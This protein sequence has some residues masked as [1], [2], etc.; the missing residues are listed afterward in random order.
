M[1]NFKK[2]SLLSNVACLAALIACAP[3]SDA[4]EQILI[5]DVK[6]VDEPA[7]VIEAQPVQP[8]VEQVDVVIVEEDI[9]T[10]VAPEPKCS[11]EAQQGGLII[12]QLP[13]GTEVSLEGVKVAIVGEAGIATIGLKQQQST[14]AIITWDDGIGKKGTIEVPVLPRKDEYR[15]IQGFNCDKVDA[16]TPEQ[17]KHAGESWVKKVEAFANLNSPKS[18]IIAFSKPS[19]GPYSS[20]FGP[21]RKYIG[22]SKVTGKPCESMSVHRGLDMAV[23]VGTELL[24]PMAGTVTLADPDL[25]YEGGAIFL[26]HGYGLVSVFMHLSEVDVKAGQIVQSGER[27]GATGNTGRTT[28]PHL[29]WSVKWQNLAREDRKGDFYIDP[30]IVLELPEW[31]A[32]K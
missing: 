29:H 28:G 4:D 20:P 8:I 18:S 24:A 7:E 12:C 6:T 11:K 3:V 17:K 13:V 32:S 26:D 10:H 19:D 27:L 30:A 25:Y 23:P 14:P 15:E 21:T 22:V 1:T 16:R 5:D 2:F 9:P 31:E